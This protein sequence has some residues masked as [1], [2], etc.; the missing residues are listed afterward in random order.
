VRRPVLRPHVENTARDP[1][2]RIC[3]GAKVRCGG[4][5]VVRLGAPWILFDLSV[6]GSGFGGRATPLRRV[7]QASAAV[8]AARARVRGVK[9]VLVF[10]AALLFSALVRPMTC[11][12]G[13]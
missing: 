2:Q 4:S 12:H 13:I 5:G 10:K 8:D 11:T 7:A 6:E 1:K 3:G 9:V